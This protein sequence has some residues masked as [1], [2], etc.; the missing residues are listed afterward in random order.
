MAFFIYLPTSVRVMGR[1]HGSL[2]ACA[3]LCTAVGTGAARAAARAQAPNQDGF[4]I[5]KLGKI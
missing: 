4:G 5:E 1:H 2:K 3:E